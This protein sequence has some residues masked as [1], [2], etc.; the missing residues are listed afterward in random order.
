MTKYMGNDFIS[1][2]FKKIDQTGI[3]YCVLRGYEKL[4]FQC[5]NDIDIFIEEQIGWFEAIQKI[6]SELNYNFFVKTNIDAFYSIVVYKVFDDQESF[7]LQVD[8]WT[9]LNQRGVPWAKTDVI[10]G[11]RRL[12][13]DIYVASFGVEGYISGL[14][15][16]FG[17]GKIPEKYH[18]LI[19]ENISIDKK[20]FFDCCVDEL[21]PIIEKYYNFF[22]TNN[23]DEAFKNRK[24]I[25]RLLKNTGIVS[26]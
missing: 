20:S 19:N 22:L 3:K 5:G 13:N 9:S 26:A 25:K 1:S 18:R 11:T 23:Y 8:F 21:K 12:F 2:F 14:K 10:I 16:L 17:N 24:Q 6:L 7:R 15:E 4:P